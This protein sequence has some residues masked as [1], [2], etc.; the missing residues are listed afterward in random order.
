MYGSVYTH[1][2]PEWETHLRVGVVP[3][4]FSCVTDIWAM[5]SS[6]ISSGDSTVRWDHITHP[7]RAICIRPGEPS[8]E[9]LLSPLTL[10]DPECLDQA[11]HFKEAKAR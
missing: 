1:T 11:P 9:T 7:E 4:Y 2:N 5:L 3:P 10:E 6:H 8:T